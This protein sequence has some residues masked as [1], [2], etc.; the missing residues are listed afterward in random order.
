MPTLRNKVALV[1]GAAR[2]IGAETSRALARKGVKLVL[3]DLDAEP[4]KALAAELGDDVALAATADVC[5]LAAVQKTVDAGVAKFGGIDLVLANAGIASYGSVLHVDPAT[6]KRVIDI[7]ILGV[8]HT[9]RAA[10]PSVIDRKGYILV[11]SSLAAFAPAPGLA[12]YN[13]SKAGI[14]H[15][16]NTLRLEVAHHGVTVGSAHMS[17]IDTPLVQDAKADLPA[18]NQ[19]L[20]A[21]PGP[22][23]K[24][25]S[26]DS[27]VDAFV[28]ALAGRKR[29][30]Y[31]PRWVELVGWL[32]AVVTSPIGDRSLLP[33]VPRILP[34]MDEE[35]AKLGRS[36]SARNVALGDV[37]VDPK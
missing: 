7:N 23:G 19:L 28:D 20:A 18:F 1:T 32:K 5:D 16:A 2:G 10:L 34:L 35:V 31:V 22:L 21:L 29:R 9:V 3:I 4:L 11:V 12:A 37:A 15:F 24:T 36:T 33:H 14:E 26:V 27:C 8:F 6:F 13:T 30:V 25:T 17:W